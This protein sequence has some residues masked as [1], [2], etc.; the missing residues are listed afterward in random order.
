MPTVTPKLMITQFNTY[1]KQ[2]LSIKCHLLH[3]R[4]T[5]HPKCDII[6]KATV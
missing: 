3:I 4:E 2:N 6:A 1:G 5:S